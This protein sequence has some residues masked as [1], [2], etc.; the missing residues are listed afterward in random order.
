MNRKQFIDEV[1]NSNECPTEFKK[2][3]EGFTRYQ[4]LALNTLKA[5]HK[6]CVA[7]GIDY[8][9]AY[10][11]LL[12]AIRDG[13]QIPW[14]YDIDVFV[15]F[16][17]KVKLINALTKDLPDNYYFY[18]PENSPSC[19]HMIMRVSPRGYRSE[20]LHVDV[21]YLIGTPNN[22]LER[23]KYISQV[24]K[25]SKARF[26]K[27][28]DIKDK[29]KGRPRH[30]AKLLLGKLRYGFLSV[31]EIDRRYKQLCNRYTLKNSKVCVSAD[32]F[33]DWYEFPC[34]VMTDIISY[35]TGDG[36]FMIPRNYDKVLKIEYGDYNNVP[37]LSGRLEELMR[38]YS[39]LERYE[40]EKA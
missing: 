21:F 20:A 29:A 14:D 3:Y 39:L 26:Y 19:R 27:L 5:F 22:E 36:E 30:A 37:K 40:K 32:Q 13:G 17:Q 25:V 1:I 4:E 16:D 12:G 35:G 11:S 6:V 38:H 31:S 7:N 10:G 18:C 34:N 15:P 28:V 33:A 23:K 24:R 8:Q 2:I 9:L